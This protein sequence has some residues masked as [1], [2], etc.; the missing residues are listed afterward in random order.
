MPE[1][2]KLN[3]G[4]P[5]VEVNPSNMPLPGVVIQINLKYNPDLLVAIR[6]HA[7]KRVFAVMQ[8][9]NET[10]FPNRLHNVGVIADI[11]GFSDIEPLV[12]VHGQTRNQGAFIEDPEIGYWTAIPGDEIRDEEEKFF[13]EKNGEF[14]VNP[15]FEPIIRG[16]LSNLKHKMRLLL[17]ELTNYMDSEMDLLEK[18]YDS[19]E[20][21]DLNKLDTINE[22][23]W[24]TIAAIPEV[25]SNQ[26]QHILESRT[27]RQRISHCL[28]LLEINIIVINNAK[29]FEVALK[30]PHKGQRG[31]KVPINEINKKNPN[32]DDGDEFES[33]NDDLKKRWERYKK[34]K[35]GLIPA[36]QKAFMEDFNHLNS[37]HQEQ[38][39]WTVFKNH[40]DFLLDLYSLTITPQET[41]ITKV[42]AKLGRSHYGLDDIKER[43]YNY[44]ATKL[45]NPKGKGPIICLVGPPGVGKTSIGQSIAESLSRKFIRL[46][47]GGV[48]DEAE[49]RGHRSTYIGALPGRILSEIRRCGCKNPV[50]M[51]DEIDKLSNDFRGDPSSA[52]LEVLDPEQNHSFQD[53]YVG[54]PFDL[55]DVLFLCT[56]NVASS[57]QPPLLDRMD[58]IP[59]SGYTEDEKIEI[60]KQYLIPKLEREVG[61]AKDNIRLGW[62][63]G[64][65]DK[66]I[67]KI[68]T[69]YTR[70]AGVRK[71][72]QKIQQ[73]LE[74]LSREHMKQANKS[75][76]IIVATESVEKILKIPKYTGERVSETEIGEAIG[77]VVTGSGNGD[78]IY[79]QAQFFPK[80]GSEKGI[81]Q[82]GQLRETLREANKNA[83]TVV[84]NLLESN[85][86]ILK[87]LRTHSLHLSIPDGATPKDGPSAG[88]T[89]AT[90]IYSELT[91][92]VAKPY[93]A[94][95]GEITIKGKIRA[96]GGIKEKVL[97]AYRDGI[98][99]IILPAAN[100]RDYEQDIRQEIKDGMNF[101]FVE[102]FRDVLPIVFT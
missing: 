56:A 34:I 9:L 62:E 10:D 67:S 1:K 42:E 65:P 72:E 4:I 29:G 101:N 12:L 80:V 63:G 2:S 64:K 66:I 78:I 77:L 5:L 55:S 83:L 16:L 79:V 102:H 41:D 6:K 69:G 93:I 31:R 14:I 22:L 47:L 61:L 28:A 59:I 26:K 40:L 81:S 68:I 33:N 76:A 30:K 8:K 18:L 37:G 11:N 39:D 45:R 98:K 90:A 99:E 35:D 57:I 71:L 3:Q 19:F 20:N 49:I 92:K 82:T 85:D 46:S 24:F 7:V 100:K 17:A 91:R 32:N 97:A 43:I 74:S 15:D 21:L 38:Q 73:I 70:E 94:M 84:K 27:P 51:L 50:F 25:D 95:T 13:I 23:V 53:H 54:A 87:K 75:L 60:A 96:V 52:F 44:L 58:V 88:I 89:M 86:E 36:V 48:R